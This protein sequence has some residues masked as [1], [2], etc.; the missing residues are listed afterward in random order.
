L[1]A[2]CEQDHVECKVCHEWCGDELCRHLTWVD[3]GYYGCGSWEVQTESHKASLM[4]LLSAIQDVRDRETIENL[5]ESI[6]RGRFSTCWHGSIL[7]PENLTL[8]DWRRHKCKNG[9]WETFNMYIADLS[10][11]EMQS[12]SE[13]YGDDHD[14][15]AELQEGMAWL[16][17][18]ECKVTREANAVTVGWIDEFLVEARCLILSGARRADSGRAK[19][20]APSTMK[21][22]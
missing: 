9:K 15:V 6:S 14:P 3:H 20:G 7:G 4:K 22:C 11:S 8:C 17:S 16:T 1:C 12:W 10:A 19:S 18:L 5:R 21:F 2:D 13:K